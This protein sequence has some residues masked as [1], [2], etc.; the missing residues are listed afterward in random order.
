MNDRDFTHLLYAY[1]IRSVGNPELYKAFDSKLNEVADRLDYPSLFNA[2]YYM[3]FR[4]SENLET[5]KKLISATV[6]N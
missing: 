4:E 5:W 3:L 6:N 2:I 1:S